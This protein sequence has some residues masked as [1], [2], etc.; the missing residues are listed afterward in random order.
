[1]SYQ[2]K[3]MPKLIMTGS[4]DFPDM[5]EE[6]LVRIVDDPVIMRKCAS[7]QV[8]DEWGEI[9]PKK[10]KSMV[11]VLALGAHESTGSNQNGDT[12]KE[13]FLKKAHPTFKEFGALYRNHKKNY[14]KR[15][16][17]I[18]K[19]AYND[20]MRRAEL[21]VSA[22]HEK[23]ADWLSELEKGNRVNFS[24]G[25]DCFAPWTLVKTINGDRTIESLKEG[26]LVL[27]HSGRY[28]AVEKVLPS[29]RGNRLV[30]E[31]KMQTSGEPLFA[32]ED[33]KILVVRKG[34][35]RRPGGGRW[36]NYKDRITPD[37]VEAGQI[38][39]GD[40]MLRPVRQLGG[41]EF[42]PG[43]AYLLGQYIGDGHISSCTD[44][45]VAI[46]TNVND[47]HLLNRMVQECLRLQ[48][49]F[50][51]DY[52]NWGQSLCRKKQATSLRIRNPEF[53]RM[54]E[55]F[56]GRTKDKYVRNEVWTWSFEAVMN[57]LG[58]YIDADG[59]Y[60][61]EGGHIRT[62]C[63]LDRMNDSIQQLF[64][65]AGV[66]ATTWKDWFG[67]RPNGSSFGNKREYANI[68]FVNKSDAVRMA[69]Y[70]SK[71]QPGISVRE[72]ECIFFVY[73]GNHYLAC[74]V[75]KIEAAADQPETVYCLTV[76]EDH[77][78][79][80]EGAVVHNCEYDICSICGNKAPTRKDYC[81]HVKKKAKPP[82]GMGKILPDGR[83]CF[84]DNPKGVFNDISKVGT[85][86]DMTAQALRK[87]AGLDEEEVIGGAELMESL[88][89]GNSREKFASK[90]AVVEKLSRMEK[91]IPI[92][93]IKP[94]ED[95]MKIRSKTAEA[96]RG[97][98]SA[99]MF[100][101][102]A[103]A[104]C[105]LPFR[106]FCDLIFGSE[107]HAFTGYVDEGEKAAGL[108]MSHILDN[109]DVLD[110][111]CANSMF[112]C[113]TIPLSKL[114][115]DDRD[116][117]M[118]EFCMDDVEAPR[119]RLKTAMIGSRSIEPV[120]PSSVSKPAMELLKAYSAYKIAAIESGSF[121]LNDDLF[122]NV[123]A[124]P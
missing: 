118:L 59:S 16:G 87:A 33:H 91:Q 88:F 86:A 112:E 8:V 101:E 100:G 43:I 54:C 103:K 124:L 75:N 117:L 15:D 74:P 7:S 28:M 55:V 60:D 13:N 14:A 71:V 4:F 115:T 99:D 36:S 102:L 61:Q 41:E 2:F 26:D 37:W 105:V 95:D 57:F 17:E 123:A 34:S 39:T 19:T 20:E 56:C 6:L 106:S 22:D 70:S 108:M 104:G 94:S 50:S 38:E 77:S 49:D 121:D 46:T 35:V 51:V 64:F 97:M 23:C 58:G 44:N 45:S 72:Q 29:L 79:V 122:F 18:E 81:E 110:E 11:H 5:H 111:V 98:E 63:V 32:T 40:Y 25:F 42:D 116:Y 68:L 66:V 113:A 96:L 73:E 24:M 78:F 27:T 90:M 21:L 69:G 120:S 48:W 3:Y 119:R 83:K 47:Q 12:F 76:A 1:M 89:P 114:A 92:S 9:K 65:S 107:K 109:E 62:A 84:V 67:L 82:F 52:L 53:A 31:M 80:A 10:G 85:G 30:L 93:V